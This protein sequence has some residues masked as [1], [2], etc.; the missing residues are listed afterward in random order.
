MSLATSSH[1]HQRL[2][3]FPHLMRAHSGY[4]HLRQPLGHLR[5]IAAVALEDLRMELTFTISG[6]LHILNPARRGDQVTGVVPVAIAIAFGAALAPA[7]SDERV[8]FLAHHPL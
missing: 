7:D 2:G 6:H 4:Q 1:S 3:V 5:F 8:E